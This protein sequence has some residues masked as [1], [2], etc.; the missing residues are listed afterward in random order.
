MELMHQVIHL[1]HEFG[2]SFN[3]FLALTEVDG[4]AHHGSIASGEWEKLVVIPLGAQQ[5]LHL[6]NSDLGFP[7]AL[8]GCRFINAACL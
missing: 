2:P 4:L 1:K 3:A 8:Q 7:N 5:G 6:P